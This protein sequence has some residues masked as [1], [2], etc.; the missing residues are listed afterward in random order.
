MAT[1]ETLTAA[2]VSGTNLS[3]QHGVA[4]ARINATIDAVNTL[5]GQGET[6]FLK[7][8]ADATELSALVVTEAHDSKLV[9]VGGGEGRIYRYT[10]GSDDALHAPYIVDSAGSTGRWHLVVKNVVLT[11]AVANLTELGALVVGAYMLSQVVL[12]ADQKKF[13][14]YVHADATSVS[15]PNVV[16]SAE[17]TGRWFAM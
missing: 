6:G 17:N 1:I 13:Y 4:F 14:F 12:V 7:E 16:A 9:S 11:S 5:I 3:A 10:H 2:D 15:S 8:V